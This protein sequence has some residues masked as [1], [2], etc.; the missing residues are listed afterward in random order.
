[1]LVIV[2]QQLQMQLRNVEQQVC[3]LTGQRDDA[4]SRLARASEEA[5]QSAKAVSNLQSVL[6][7]FQRGV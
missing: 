1:M 5:E 7:L 3:V 2:S 6:E 4:L